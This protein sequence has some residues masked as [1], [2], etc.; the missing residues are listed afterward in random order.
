MLMIIRYICPDQRVATRANN[1]AGGGVAGFHGTV[2]SLISSIPGCYLVGIRH[3]EPLLLPRQLV[4][5]LYRR[6]HRR[7]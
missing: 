7:G 4:I 1:I 5:A 6:H 2:P 3:Q